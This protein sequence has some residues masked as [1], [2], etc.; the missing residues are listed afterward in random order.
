M[1]RKT[2]S[3]SSSPLLQHR[4]SSIDSTA[5]HDSFDSVSLDCLSLASTATLKTNVSLPNPVQLTVD[6][7]FK[8]E[9]EKTEGK[10]TADQQENS[11]KKKKLDP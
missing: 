9:K 10:R 8:E 1:T 5:S 3:P 2:A 11:C 7:F 4:R 6:Q